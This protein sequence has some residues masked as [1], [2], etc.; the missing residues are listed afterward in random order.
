MRS[1]RRS[2]AR[3]TAGL[4]AAPAEPQ[5]EQHDER[6]RRPPPIRAGT[7]RRTRP[8]AWAAAAPCPP[9]RSL[10]ELRHD[11]DQEHD[12]RYHGDADQDRRI[13]QRGA[14][15]LAQ[16]LVA[17]HRLGEALQHHAERA[18]RFA[19]AHD[20]DVEAREDL[21][22]RVERLRQRL[23]AA[24]VVAHALQQRGHRRR[25]READQDLHRAIERQAGAQQR[26]ELARD[27]EELIA[28]DVLRRERDAGAARARRRPTRRRR[29]PPTRRS[30]S[31]SGPG[32]AG[33]R[34]DR[35]RWT[36]RDSPVD[37]FAGRAD[38]AITVRR[39]RQSRG[40]P[41]LTPSGAA[42]EPRVGAVYASR[43]TRST[44]SNVVTPFSAL[45]RP[46]SYIVSMPSRTASARRSVAMAC[47]IT[48][49]RR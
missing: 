13:D 47:F 35:T 46:S 49:L 42:N 18:A 45:R 32:R 20:V 15:V 23:A 28:R 19:R 25:G 40:R 36:H 12:H 22:P 6:E 38:G 41:G 1:S 3:R 14:D 26:R 21:A 8:S 10:L 33:G 31:A 30:V 4:R 16:L 9:A 44:S 24:H 5:R 37:D 43:V 2:R 29:F 17:L 11:E 27:R 7:C 39:H 48:M 34:R